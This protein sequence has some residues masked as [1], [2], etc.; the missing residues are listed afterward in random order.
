MKITRQTAGIRGTVRFSLFLT[1]ML[2]ISLFFGGFTNQAGGVT[3]EEIRDAILRGDTYNAGID[4][5]QDGKVDVADLVKL[6]RSMQVGKSA[7]RVS[8]GDGTVKVR[9]NFAS[10]FTGTLGISVSGTAVEGTDYQTLPRSF[11]MDRTSVEIPITLID[12]D[13]VED[14]KTIVLT[15]S[16]E[17]NNGSKTIPLGAPAD[18]TVYIVDNDSLWRGTI[19]NNGIA[20]HF[21]M[22]IIQVG[23]ETKGYLVTDGY[24]IIPQNGTGA[25]PNEWPAT[26]MTLRNGLFNATVDSVAI[27]MALTLTNVD[28]KREF[29]FQAA[30]GQGN[31]IVK[32]DSEIRGTVTESIK[33]SSE[34]YLNRTITGSFTL[35]KQI[36]KVSAISPL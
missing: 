3:E 16:Y 23:S 27:P 1:P 31:H 8:E 5:N 6:L 10:R 14:V 26:T 11:T 12:D 13:V 18:Y 35:L 25:D 21:Q 30:S 15:F 32:P 34:T 22:K 2:I 29:V 36:S 28:L 7:L 24:G 19:N 4:L 20:L 33:S 9:V 17:D